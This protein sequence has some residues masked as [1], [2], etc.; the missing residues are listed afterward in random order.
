MIQR[1]SVRLLVDLGQQSV[2]PPPPLSLVVASPPDSVTISP[3]DARWVGAWWLGFFI[4]TALLLISAIPFWFLP[5]TLP[6]Q[7][8]PE[9]EGPP[10]HPHAIQEGL[11]ELDGDVPPSPEDRPAPIHKG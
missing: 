1:C 5:R 9:G 4:S 8:P 11:L 7:G 3:K 2:G 10:T 6:K